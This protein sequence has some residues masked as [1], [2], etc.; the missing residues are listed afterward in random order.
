[1]GYYG[2][3]VSWVKVL[4]LGDQYKVWSHD[5]YAKQ[6]APKNEGVEFR[7]IFTYGPKTTEPAQEKVG[8]WVPGVAG[9]G[10]KLPYRAEIVAPKD[11][12]GNIIRVAVIQKADVAVSPLSLTIPRLSVMDFSPAVD[13]DT[14]RMVILNHVDHDPMDWGTYI[15]GF[16]WSVWISLIALWL[17]MSIGIA[18]V[19]ESDDDITIYNYLFYFIGALAQQGCAVVPSYFRGRVIL[20]FF[21]VGSVLLYASYTA[22]LTSQLAVVPDQQPFHSLSEA[23]TSAGYYLSTRKGTSYV[24]EMKTSRDEGLRK[25]YEQLMDD[26]SLLV[27]STKDGIQLLHSRERKVVFMLDVN[28][29]GYELQG[30]CSYKWVG[31]EYFP[32]Y[33]YI[34][35]RKNLSYANVLSKYISKAADYGITYKLRERW[36]YNQR[37]CDT[38]SAFRR[39]T[40]SKTVMAF[41]I[42]TV[43]ACLGLSI[44]LLERFVKYRHSKRL[45][46]VFT[47]K[48]AWVKVKKRRRSTLYKQVSELHFINK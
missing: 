46:Y 45:L 35:Y 42:L 22:C 32:E 41:T 13:H 47:S 37:Q 26:P 10:K 28:S 7:E 43:G 14:V 29:I 48:D 3:P 12:R 44:L 36:Q 25:A 5:P 33:V 27:D 1:M 18:K 24:S 23:I 16:H 6:T 39:L 34:G 11:F 19:A 17:V 21:W 9:P 38:G 8:L 40:F 20:F 2:L 15:E 4:L 30:S 31:P